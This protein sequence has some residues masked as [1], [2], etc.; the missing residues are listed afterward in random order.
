MPPA[1]WQTPVVLS[2]A[3]CVGMVALVWLGY[4]ATREWKRGIDVLHERQAAEAMALADAALSRD[5]TGAW[6]TL[7]VPIQQIMIEEEPPYALLERTALAFAKFPYPESFVVW[8]GPGR[9]GRT[10]V[11]NR[12]DR[13]PPWDASRRSDDPFPVVF[14]SNAN[15][16]APVIEAVRAR[17]QSGDRFITFD[18]EIGGRPYQ[19][20][21]QLTF[22]PVVPHQLS[23][24]AAITISLDWVRDHYFGPLLAQVAKIGGIDESYRLSVTD[25]AGGLVAS[26]GAE[27]VHGDGPTRRFPLLFLDSALT[28][29]PRDA[30]GVVREWALHVRAG[31]AS[32]LRAAADT[33]DRIFVLITVAAAASIAALF[34]MVRAVRARA[35]AASMRSDFVTSVTHELKTP[36]SLIRLVA[37]TLATGR[38]TSSDHVRDY[39]GLLS[40]ESRRLTLSIDQILTYARYA[41]PNG[42]PHAELV[43]MDLADLA[44]DAL[45]HFR[46]TLDRRS[47]RLTVDVPRDL[48]R[49]LVDGRAIVQVVEILIDNALKCSDEV[50]VLT[51]TGRTEGRH[52][53]LTVTDAG[54]GI[55]HDDINRIFEQFYRGRNAN[56][57]GSGLG[58]TIANRVLHHH[59]GDITIRSTV[60]VGTDITLLFPMRGH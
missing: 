50:P 11:L 23:G 57:S 60:G 49:V 12:A 55:H 53:T 21:A 54:I 22:T 9:P 33:A 46:L 43:P 3:L 34:L 51:I 31:P 7:L 42:V 6:A 58:L 18:T 27:G 59:G 38:Y 28:V 48:P 16:M 8:R 13:P 41:G 39:A 19:V 2:V 20:L 1:L 4:V 5:M 37:D 14:A 36:L 47:A 32:T 15:A 30:R 26:T 52:V 24:V 35:V 29:P 40:Q 56:H 25:D 10:Y 44:D 45:A 17:A